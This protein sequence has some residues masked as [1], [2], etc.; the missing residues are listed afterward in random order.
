MQFSEDLQHRIAKAVCQMRPS[1]YV[2]RLA[3]AGVLWCAGVS[4]A[5]LVVN[6]VL[7]EVGA[8]KNGAD[9][10]T[11][12]YSTLPLLSPFSI[13]DPSPPVGTWGTAAQTVQGYQGPSGIGASWLEP[14]DVAM[15]LTANATAV[16]VGGGL[17]AAADAYSR[18]EFSFQISESRP[19]S[20]TFAG[21]LSPGFTD[22]S[23]FLRGTGV[24]R[25]AT[26]TSNQQWS[27]TLG[28]GSYTFGMT[29]GSYAFNNTVGAI[30]TGQL[31]LAAV[32]EPSSVALLGLVTGAVLSANWICRAFSACR[33]CESRDE[34]VR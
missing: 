24:D 18:F 20:V 30:S 2:R 25:S 17:A 11:N 34:R 33:D 22:N 9:Y 12:T 13:S 7:Q 6:S 3:I 16:P 4:Y 8:S 1:V 23:V 31:Q 27:G 19:Y 26:N 10:V 14:L 15:Q 21:D 28:P 5:D 29:A 32:P